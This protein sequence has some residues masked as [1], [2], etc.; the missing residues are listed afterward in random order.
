MS[1][2]IDNFFLKKSYKIMII[3]HVFTEIQKTND[4]ELA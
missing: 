3:L 1:L 4:N 2:F